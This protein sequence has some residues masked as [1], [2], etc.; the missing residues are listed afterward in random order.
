MAQGAGYGQMGM[1]GTGAI[2]GGIGDIL[3][4]T[5]YHQPKYPDPTEQERRLRRL[6]QS[7]L[8][9]GGQELLAGTHL[10]NQ[11]APILMSQLPGMHYVP[12][13]GGDTGAT[14]G[15]TGGGGGLDPYAQALQTMQQ[16]RARQTQLDAM[17]AQIKGMKKG[18][19]RRAAIKQRKEL[20]QQV[21][22][23]VPEWRL[24]QDMFR[25]GAQPEPMDIRQG[26]PATPQSSLG[27]IND[28]M[29][30]LRPPPGAGGGSDLLAAYHAGLSGG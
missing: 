9:G 26:A 19:D 5:N 1:A 29:A 22:G 30:S 16:N 6:A 14:T 23:Q 18:P 7:Q 17:N 2:L 24:Q 27:S 21:K 28:L 10:Y 13:S 8:L 20:K 11:L 12:G 25:S 3:Q 4:A 15:G